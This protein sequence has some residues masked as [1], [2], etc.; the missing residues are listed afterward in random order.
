MY[1]DS[2]RQ[3]QLVKILLLI[4]GYSAVVKLYLHTRR[5]LIYIC[6]IT[7]I[8]VEYSAAAAAVLAVPL[9]L[10]VVDKMYYLVSRAEY[11]DA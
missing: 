7:Y 2:V 4:R 5:A 8:T 1:A 10:I 6:D 9:H 11:I 3:S